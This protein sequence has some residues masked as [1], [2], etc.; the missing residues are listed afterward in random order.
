MGVDRASHVMRV[1]LAGITF[2][3]AVIMRDSI[4]K[5]LFVRL[6]NN[7]DKIIGSFVGEPYAREVHWTGKC[8]EECAGV[9]CSYCNEG[10]RPS[11]R[12]SMNF[13]VPAERALRVIE[14]GVMWFK[15]LLKVRDKYGLDKWTFEVE[16]HGD[17]G[18]LRTYYTISPDR[19]LTADHLKEIE[20]LR[21]HD[22]TK[23][24]T[25]AR[26]YE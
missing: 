7:G 13:H 5:G 14:G 25:G 19:Q 9:G 8:Y 15:D 23:I 3:G 4:T 12:V 2:N 24:Y 11:L 1:Y 26:T 21:L 18:D 20:A 16:R 22:L 10:K 17:A 6:T